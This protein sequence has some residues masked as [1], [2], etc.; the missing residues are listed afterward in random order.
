M[1][2]SPLMDEDDKR[3]TVWKSI[4]IETIKS[5]DQSRE[6]RKCVVRNL[7]ILSF[8]ILDSSKYV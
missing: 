1:K 8:V 4:K 6:N 5:L 3:S 7:N 2:I